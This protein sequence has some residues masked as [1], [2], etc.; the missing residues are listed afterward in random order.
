MASYDLEL[1]PI[2]SK[3]LSKA[4]NL[5][6]KQSEFIHISMD[7]MG[8]I[9]TFAGLRLSS[10]DEAGVCILCFH[11]ESVYFTSVRLN[12]TT[13][14]SPALFVNSKL[15]TKTFK[16]VSPNRIT[17]VE[18]TITGES[19]QFKFH[20]K[21]GITSI[22]DVPASMPNDTSPIAPQDLPATAEHIQY[23][24]FSTNPKYMS[25]LLELFPVSS[26]L[27]A[28]SLTHQADENQTKG[29]S[30]YVTNAC[31][32]I[33]ESSSV[34]GLTISQADLNRNS[35]YVRDAVFPVGHTLKLPL[36]EF[37]GITTLLCDEV[38]GDDF[39]LAIGF[40]QLGG[41]FGEGKQLLVVHA[42]PKSS[43]PHSAFCVKMWFKGSSAPLM[44]DYEDSVKLE[45][46]NLDEIDPHQTVSSTPFI[47]SSTH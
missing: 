20:W 8:P 25:G 41:S 47:I 30:L 39:S 18:M 2:S 33:Q 9:G 40:S 21:N 23:V 36:T 4:F 43:S 19:L 32:G 12:T 44:N 10:I 22:K 38:L 11:F 16:G 27:W 14:S 45:D 35:T 24:S 31:L 7:L 34:V 37:R 15:V 17:K 29:T 5:I 13:A 28:L 1:N 3:L 26:T 42:V 6:Q 46:L